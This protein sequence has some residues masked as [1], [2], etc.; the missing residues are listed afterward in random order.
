M[1]GT[2]VDGVD[3]SF[4]ETNG[5]NYVKNISGKSYKY[6]NKYK[7][8]VKIFIKKLRNNTSLPLD[9][10]D[11]FISKQFLYYIN[12]FICEFKINISMIDYIGLSGQTVL[13]KPECK[14]TIQLGSGK[15][16]SKSLNVNVVSNFR[17]ND[18]N[19]GGQG[20]PIGAFYIKYLLHKLKIKA[21]FINIGGI[22]NIAF[23][24]HLNQLSAFDLGPGNSLID[25]YIWS[26]LKKNYDSEGIISFKGKSNKTILKEF[27]NDRFFKKQYPKSLDR[28]YFIHF[29][30]KI[31]KLSIEDA[32]STLSM[33]TV[34]GIK[35][36]ID[37]LDTKIHKIILTGGGRKNN[38]LFN[39]LK[40]ITNL[41]IID[42]DKFGL[43]G[44][45]LEAEAFAYI[46]AR[47][48]KNLPL[49]LRTTTGVKKPVTG[50]ILNKINSV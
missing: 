37:L 5:T 16:L 9:K 50:G 39:K 12:K 4:I 2:S 25:D 42:I 41:E 27:I 22:S 49:S 18:I 14:L 19:N 13:H 23:I 30:K 26:R 43:D 40:E 8:K 36:G 44:D 3:F 38:F 21:A 28:E 29:I 31:K 33:M 45:L 32:M 46:T 24:N 6:K 1:S 34:I 47:S 11:L 17:Q 35:K 7:N 20:A 48:I 15:F 10:M